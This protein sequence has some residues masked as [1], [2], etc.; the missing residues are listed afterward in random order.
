MA[1]DYVN[2]IGGVYNREGELFNDDTPALRV[3]RFIRPTELP[4]E[5]D[6]FPGDPE[7]PTIRSTF[8]DEVPDRPAARKVVAGSFAT[9]RAARSAHQHEQKLWDPTYL[10]AH[11]GQSGVSDPT[12]AALAQ[13]Y[14]DLRDFSYLPASMMPTEQEFFDAARPSKRGGFLAE[15]LAD[16]GIDSASEDDSPT[17]EGAVEGEAAPRLLL[18]PFV[19]STRRGCTERLESLLG[20]SNA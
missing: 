20:V 3:R 19:P 10:P 18:P 5:G 11:V 8:P 15:H 1:S 4:E 7:R 17:L 13:Q 2:K 16:M 6:A 12:D 14:Q 9:V